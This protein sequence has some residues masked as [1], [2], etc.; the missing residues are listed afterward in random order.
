MSEPVQTPFGWHL[1]R[2]DRDRARADPAVRVG[3]GRDRSASWRSERATSQLP[4]FATKLD[5]ELAAGTP[6]DAAAE[7][8]GIDAA[9]ARE[10]RPAPATRRPRSGSRA[11]RLT[12]DMLTPI[13]AAAPGRDLAARADPGRPLLHVPRRRHRPGA[14]APA[15]RGPRRGERRPG[16]TEEQKKR[17]HAR[18]EEL[19]PQAG[20]RRRLWRRSPQDN[21]D[22]RLIE[23]GPVMRTDDG[24]GAGARRAPAVQAMFATKAGEVATDVVDVPRRLG[25][26]RGRRGP[27]GGSRRADGR[28]ATDDALLSSLRRPRCWPPTRRRCGRPTRSR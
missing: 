6:L 13:F 27:A 10:H 19:R 9:E 14:R 1:L 12:A 24:P 23:I 2:V 18:A 15:G 20:P 7:K 26:R 8:L 17:A 21:A 22:L 16:S 28:R 3:E 4:D 11:D 5:D 25:D